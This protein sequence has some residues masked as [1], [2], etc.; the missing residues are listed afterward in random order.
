MTAPWLIWGSDQKMRV[1]ANGVTGTTR[2]T[3]PQLALID[4]ARPETWSFFLAMR[5]ESFGPP[6]LGPGQSFTL[7]A[8][9]NTT[10]G[11]ARTARTF[12]LAV[13]SY[14]FSF[15]L[16]SAG[17]S[18]ENLIWTTR[19][20]TR[21]RLPA[22]QSIL[23]PTDWVEIDSFPAQS[24]NCAVEVR[25]STTSPG[26]IPIDLTVT[27]IFAPKSHIRPEWFKDG[28]YPGGENNGV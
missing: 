16:N 12:P 25:A 21:F 27:A 3:S 8:Y 23:V 14:V 5:M 9:F 20:R 11:L 2:T 15:D 28:L 13:L 1:I 24:I 18:P 4:Y 26:I 17:K 22:D 10:I 7:D 6:E 19:T